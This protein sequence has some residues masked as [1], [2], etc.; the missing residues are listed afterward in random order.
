MEC[1]RL[2]KQKKPIKK[3]AKP[4]GSKPPQHQ[5]G[6]R[7]ALKKAAVMSLLLITSTTI[8][9]PREMDLAGLQLACVDTK[10]TRYEFMDKN[11]EKWASQA[12]TI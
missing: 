12:V 7:Q 11:H 3:P 1:L 10:L 2:Q 6:L 4:R 8:C 9:N 5:K